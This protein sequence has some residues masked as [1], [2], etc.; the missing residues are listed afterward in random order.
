ML[1]KV[2]RKLRRT[3]DELQPT[4]CKR[5]KRARGGGDLIKTLQRKYNFDDPIY[6]GDGWTMDGPGMA[7][8]APIVGYY[9]EDPGDP[10]VVHGGPRGMQEFKSKDDLLDY[11][12]RHVGR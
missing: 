4:L 9:P 8:D 12:D 6:E 11:V 2:A 5:C 3:A 1:K 7:G 10:W